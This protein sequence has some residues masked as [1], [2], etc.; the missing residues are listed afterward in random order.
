[1]TKYLLIIVVLFST[2]LHGQIA[3]KVYT[4][5][6]VYKGTRAFDNRLPSNSIIYYRI[7]SVQTGNN[8]TTSKLVAVNKKNSTFFEMGR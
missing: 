6:N 4:N 3:D 5:T 7:R 2:N 1:M 8:F